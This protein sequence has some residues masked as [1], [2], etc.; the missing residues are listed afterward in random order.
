MIMLKFRSVAAGAEVRIER[1]DESHGNPMPAY[2]AMGS[3]RYP[4]QAQIARMNQASAPAAPEKRRLKDG[5][6]PLQLPVNGL[7]MMEIAIG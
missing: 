5:A 4:T 3:P 7:A 2:R 1:V 6:L